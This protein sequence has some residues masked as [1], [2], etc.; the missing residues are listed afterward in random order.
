MNCTSPALHPG[1][2]HFLWFAQW[3]QAGWSVSIIKERVSVSL[4]WSS[5]LCLD[6]VLISWTTDCDIGELVLIYEFLQWSARLTPEAGHR[7]CWWGP[8][9]G[10]LVC[11]VGGSCCG[12]VCSC[13]QLN[14]EYVALA[15]CVV[16]AWEVYGNGT[17]PTKWNLG[18]TWLAKYVVIVDKVY[19]SG[20]WPT[21]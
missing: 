10:G 15:C 17:C 12:L 7:C 4:L 8:S 11:H 14:L 2:P 5:S 18:L 19:E 1:L 6:I 16:T 3:V 13:V 9:R 20:T 21:Q